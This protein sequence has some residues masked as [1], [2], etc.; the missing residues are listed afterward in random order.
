MTHIVHPYAQRL[1]ILRGW[2]SRW[3]GMGQQYRDYL[4]TDILIREFLEKKLR[5]MYVS[6]IE[7]ERDAKRFK[8][9]IRTSR[10]GVIIGRSGDGV[11]KIKKD[12]VKFLRKKGLAIPEEINIDVEEIRYPESDAS[13]VGAMVVEG[14]EKRMPFRRVLKMTADKVMASREVQGVRISA[15]GRLGGAEM[16]RREEVKKGRIPLQTLR[17]DIDYATKRANLTYGVI[18]VKVWIYKGDV[19]NK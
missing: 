15:S 9:I 11:Q 16:A 8:I 6:S 19:F 2:K 10:A 7:M 14:L 4:K 18:G 17:A 12:V 13:I 1:K 3:F 5:D